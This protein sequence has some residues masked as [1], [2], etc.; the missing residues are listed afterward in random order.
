M[1]LD[2]QKL[3]SIRRQIKIY[4]KEC[5]KT[6]DQQKLYDLSKKIEALH[7]EEAI[8]LKELDVL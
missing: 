8:L 7:T 5:R 6:T 3:A 2:N 4:E 1:N